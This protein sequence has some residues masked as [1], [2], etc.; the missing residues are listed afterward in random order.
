M[1]EYN[2]PTKFFHLNAMNTEFLV[3]LELDHDTIKY[4]T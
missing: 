2:P 3:V 1:S 4:Y